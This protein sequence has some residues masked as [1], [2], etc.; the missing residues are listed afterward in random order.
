MGTKSGAFLVC[1]RYGLTKRASSAALERLK[2]WCREGE[3]IFWRPNFLHNT[4]KNATVIDLQTGAAPRF[5][6][7]GA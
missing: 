6:P 3:F 4:A 7:F 1:G 2:L 5:S